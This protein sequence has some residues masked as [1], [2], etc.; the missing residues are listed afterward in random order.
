MGQIDF[1]EL[2]WVG[3]ILGCL[4]TAASLSAFWFLVLR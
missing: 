1:N 3:F 4:V 2:F